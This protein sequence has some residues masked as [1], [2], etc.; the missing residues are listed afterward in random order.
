MSLKGKHILLGITGGI[1]AYKIP[2]LI[3]LLIKAGAEVKIMRTPSAADFVTDKTL[4][5]LSGNP[6]YSDF[7]R[8]GHIWNNHVHLARWA[9]A[10]LIAPLSANTLAKI[11]NG[12]AGNFLLATL[13]SAECPVIL[14]PAM[15]REMYQYPA[16]AENIRKAR[17]F[18]FTVLEPEEGELASGLTG[19]GRMPEPDTLF[20][21]LENLFLG[22]LQLKGKKVVITGGPTREPIDPVRYVGNRASGKTGMMLAQEAAK[23]G[24]EVVYI[25]GPS[26]Y[27]PQSP[28]IQTVQVETARE[29]FEAVKKYWPGADIM[30]MS[31]AVADYRPSQKSP[32][33]IKKKDETLELKLVKNPDIL[34]WAGENKNP[35]QILVGFALETHNE[36]QNAL[37]KMKQK[38][39][40]MI[41]LNSL[42]DQGA[43]FGTDTNKITILKNNGDEKTF[44]L[45]TKQEVAKD[46]WD[47]ITALI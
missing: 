15:D 38:N 40:D 9:D 32:Q 36:K 10:I 23:R 30:V 21:E 47:E 14:S 1:A 3:R 26:Q 8:E 43:G 42:R 24:A 18:G 20:R 12:Q 7:Y 44:P 22:N 25:T 33:K 34:A 2:L 41:V 16:V 5:A 39:L 6:V 19:K 46:I 31:A 35:G 4:S 28:N 13:M 29:M 37:K 27:L 17:S 11:V 45:K